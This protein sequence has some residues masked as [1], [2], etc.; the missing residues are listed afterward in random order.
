MR[1]AGEAL[2][3]LGDSVERL[4]APRTG[5]IDG[6]QP[7]ASPVEVLRRV[8]AMWVSRHGVSEDEATMDSLV[9]EQVDQIRHV[10][11]PLTDAPQ[12]GTG[13]LRQRP[14]VPKPG[15]AAAPRR[16]RRM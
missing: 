16:S 4:L 13:T 6:N 8:I 5:L 1:T 12:P 9:V 11:G 14:V 7:E 3:A 15:R 10:G 2:E